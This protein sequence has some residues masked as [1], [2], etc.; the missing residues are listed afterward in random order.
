[1]KK[2]K[3]LKTL[4]LGSS[5]ALVLSVASGA[6]Q[7]SEVNPFGMEELTGGYNLAM[8]EGMCGGDKSKSAE[9]EASKASEGKCGGGKSRGESGKAGKKSEGKCGEGKCGGSKAKE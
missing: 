5:A 6:I 3:K 2:I 4:S 9:G 7:A 8:S 1:M